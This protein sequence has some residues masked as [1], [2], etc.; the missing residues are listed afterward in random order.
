MTGHRNLPVIAAGLMIGGSWAG[1]FA[2]PSKAE[3]PLLMLPN[4]AEVAR[5]SDCQP[6]MQ[7]VH[8]TRRRLAC[9]VSTT[10]CLAHGGNVVRSGDNA[11][12]CR[13]SDLGY[14]KAS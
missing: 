13:G 5:E 14:A 11:D 10:V 6:P 3:D 8:A 1:L 12:F 4:A 9:M 2:S 7:V